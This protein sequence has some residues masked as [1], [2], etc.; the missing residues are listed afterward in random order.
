MKRF[1]VTSATAAIVGMAIALSQGAIAQTPQEGNLHPGVKA[2]DIAPGSAQPTRGVVFFTA[3]VN[4]DGSVA[5]CFGCKTANT[6]R[7]AV[8]RYIIDFGQNVQAVNGW[9]RWVQPDTLQTGQVGCPGG[10]CTDGPGA[11]C[12]T[13]D[14]A[15]DSNAVWVNCQHA[16]GP[17]SQGKSD[18]FDTSF[19]LFV[20]R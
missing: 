11:W 2:H 7:V 5:G 19:F 4:S 17:G 3:A 1:F 12:T 13:A 16:G 6:H 9:S 20:A 10:T 14:S 18:F 8:G 15:A